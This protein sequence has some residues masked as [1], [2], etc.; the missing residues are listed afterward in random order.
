MNERSSSRKPRIIPIVPHGKTAVAS[1]SGLEFRHALPLALY[2][3]IPWCVQKCPYCDFNSHEARGEIPEADYISALIADLESS[4]PL[5]WG[6]TVSSIFFGGGTPSL[7]S[8]AGLDRLLT[9]IRTLLP[10]L[11]DAEVTLEANPGTVES[12]KFAAFRAAGI[13]RLSLGIQSFNPAHLKALG[14]I[15]D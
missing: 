1:G 7:L 3:H 2:V 12:A 4:L 15:H 5:I 8:G 11:P 9:A 14:R 13:N 6:R 10:L